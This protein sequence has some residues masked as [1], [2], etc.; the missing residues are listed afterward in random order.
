MDRTRS[1]KYIKAN[2][3]LGAKS[4]R[5]KSLGRPGHGW[6]NNVIYFLFI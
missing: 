3:V 4:E 1:E 2:K 6:G 5:K